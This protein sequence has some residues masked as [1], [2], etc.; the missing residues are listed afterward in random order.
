[1]PLGPSGP[2]PV[3]SSLP[4]RPA[5]YGRRVLAALIDAAIG[6]GVI[7]A[8][9]ILVAVFG[10]ISDVLGV[11]MLLVTIV[12]SVGYWVWNYVI[13][14]GATGQ[15][16]GKQHQQIRLL[17]DA[18]G[19]P[20]GPGMALLRYVV[21]SALSGVSCGVAGVLD[22]LWPLWDADDKRLTDKII[23]CSVI[24]ARS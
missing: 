15:T 23:S 22:Y 1:M 20:P 4:G 18:T 3:R 6:T 21:A 2:L 19:R 12:A 16:L 9:L 17:A 13:R 14:Q 24:D 11:L 7:I 8:G 5:D 10:A